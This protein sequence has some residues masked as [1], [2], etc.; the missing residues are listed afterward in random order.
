[1]QDKFTIDISLVIPLLNEAESLPELVSQIYD[2]VF[3]LPEKKSIEILFI[4]DG[5]T[6]NSSDVIKTLVKSH[7]E[8]KLIRF[9]KNYG[10]SA[11]LD[12][13]FAAAQGEFVITMDA[14]LQDNPY[15]I[16][17]LIKKLNDGYDLVSGWKQ[18]RHDPI[19]K[20]LPSKFFNFVTG[21]LTGIPIHDFNCG[22]KAYRNEVVKSVSIYGELH[23]YIPVL[24]KFNG[25][26][27]SEIVVEHR[28]RK[29]GY[30]KFGL[31]RFFKGFLDLVTVLFITKYMKRPM[32]FFG[33]FGILCFIVGFGISLYLT[34][35]KIFSNATV[36]NRPILFLGMLLIILGVQFLSTG[37]LSEMIAKTYMQKEEYLIKEKVNV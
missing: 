16:G 4:D 35:E 18:K 31:S 1:L 22:L 12:V 24:A 9:R 10:K 26:R 5:S 2:A 29:F 11:A 36:S 28:A 15:E 13:G 33:T 17:P 19:S 3:K 25:F 37:L 34:I 21:T 27:V 8:I 23:R 30:S 20:T 6:D 32:H 14:D 7:A